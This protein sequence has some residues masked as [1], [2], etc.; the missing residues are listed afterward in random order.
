[1]AFEEV[2]LTD[3][4]TA[5]LATGGEFFRFNAIGDK[6]VGRFVKTEERVNQFQKKEIVYTFKTRTPEGAVKEVRL[7]PNVALAKMLEKAE[8]KP[9]HAAMITYTGDLPIEG[10]PHPMR[11]FKLAVDRAAGAAAP[12]PPPPPP[13]AADDLDY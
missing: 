7:S 10:K 12:K 2:K 9:G 13:P 5:A 4:E 8:L 3:E 1:M 11:M 6:L